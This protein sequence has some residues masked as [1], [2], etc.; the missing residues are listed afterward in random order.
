M[1]E[2]KTHWYEVTARHRTNPARIVVRI[3]KA[4][5]PETAEG[6]VLSAL[7]RDDKHSG[8]PSNNWTVTSQEATWL[9]N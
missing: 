4:V 7:T 6:I 5:C 2:Q 3:L 8:E 1:S 9:T